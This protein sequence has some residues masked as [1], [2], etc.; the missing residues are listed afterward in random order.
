[1]S[2]CRYFI[3]TC[4]IPY[5]YDLYPILLANHRAFNNTQYIVLFRTYRDKWCLGFLSI[6]PPIAAIKTI[7]F[8]ILWMRHIKRHHR[9]GHNP[10]ILHICD[11]WKPKIKSTRFAAAFRGAPRV[12][13]RIRNFCC[14]WNTCC[15]TCRFVY[16]HFFT[17][18]ACTGCN[19]QTCISTSTLSLFPL[20]WA[21]TGRLRFFWFFITFTFKC[22]LI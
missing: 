10:R 11:I 12:T 21:F 1:M 14:V 17:M 7:E 5:Y 9:F 8:T 16:N 20:D 6:Q 18:R 15:F 2:I 3:K 22:F 19:T 4:V 13:T